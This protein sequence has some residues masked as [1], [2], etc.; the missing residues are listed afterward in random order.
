MNAAAGFAV[1]HLADFLVDEEQAFAVFADD[2]NL[3]QNAFEQLFFFVLFSN[4]PL[5]KVE[6]GVVL[7]AEGSM[8]QFV[9]L[10][11]VMRHSCS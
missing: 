2:F 1:G 3:I 6:R 5:Q 4:V 7:I 10:T 8:C 11:L 9:N